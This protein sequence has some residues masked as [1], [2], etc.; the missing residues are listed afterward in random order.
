[1]S[2][3]LR[4]N[5]L[6]LT[7]FGNQALRELIKAGAEVRAVY[8]RKER[9][10]FPYYREEQI[11]ALAARHGIPVRYVPLRGNWRI[12]SRAD[13]NLCATFHRIL[14]QQHL[15]T[16]AVNV[17]IHPSLLP[18]YKGPTP[19]SWMIHHK[20][21]RC[22]I[23]AHRLTL[24]VDEGAIVYQKE[25][26][27][28]ATSDPRLRKFLALKTRACVRYLVAHY[29]RYREITSPYPASRHGFYHN[30]KKESA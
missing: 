10:A 17:N 6:A 3:P 7:G 13:L 8:T 21:T 25:Y 9:G 30:R 29:P 14:K 23:S 2:T 19:T 18:S 28:K 27:L 11:A 26:P 1:M 15:R 12:A 20:E 22:G 4:V 24:G 16:A 5:L